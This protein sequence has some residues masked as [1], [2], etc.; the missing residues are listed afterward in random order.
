MLNSEVLHHAL[1]P[2]SG[3]GTKGLYSTCSSDKYIQLPRSDEARTHSTTAANTSTS[4]PARQQQVYPS[5]P[6]GHPMRATT[7]SGAPDCA[8]SC[9]HDEVKLFRATY[10][11]SGSKAGYMLVR[12]QG[13]LG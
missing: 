7:T 13:G 12:G 11:G 2:L 3:V 6:L 5:S 8:Q 4:R 10:N 9:A 1:R